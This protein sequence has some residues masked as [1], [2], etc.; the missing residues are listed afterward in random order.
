[1]DLGSQLSAH[2]RVRRL[3]AQEGFSETKT[4]PVQSLCELRKRTGAGWGGGA[5]RRS[6]GWIQGNIHSTNIYVHVVAESDTTERLTHTH[7]HTHTTK[8]GYGCTTANVIKS[9]LLRNHRNESE[10]HA[11]GLGG[12]VGEGH[13]P[14]P[15]NQDASQRTRLLGCSI[16]LK[17]TVLSKE[18][19]P[20]CNYL[21]AGLPTVLSLITGSRLYKG[22][23]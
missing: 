21:F 9:L 13:L 19:I 18:F 3:R 23:D 17:Q 1:M 15:E 11:G 6:A 8:Q 14:S 12:M 16:S 20:I 4:A 7:T 2:Y 10:G 5:G 22:W